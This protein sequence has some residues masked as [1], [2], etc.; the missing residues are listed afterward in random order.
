MQ[1]AEAI[2]NEPVAWEGTDL[3]IKVAYGI[4]T[5]QGG[6]SVNDAL[7]AADREM[8]ERKAMLAFP[9]ALLC[10]ARR[11][12]IRGLNSRPGAMVD[13]S[14]KSGWAFASVAKSRA[15]SRRKVG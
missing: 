13:G 6:E 12:E 2:E 11:H 7:A 4:T 10:R 14:S 8:Y 3:L 1:L 15:I 5:F 9:V